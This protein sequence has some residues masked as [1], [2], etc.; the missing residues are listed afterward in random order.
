MR[1]L[2]VSCVLCVARDLSAFY[3]VHLVCLVSSA[4]Y[5]M[6]YQYERVVCVSTTSST[7]CLLACSTVILIYCRLACSTRSLK[8]ADQVEDNRERT[9]TWMRVRALLG[10]CPRLLLRCGV[11]ATSQHATHACIYKR[12]TC[13]RTMQVR[14]DKTVMWWWWRRRR[15]C[16]YWCW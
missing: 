11:K 12:N 10:L 8:H 2:Y 16:C 5:D 4:S 15:C 3:L 13:G 1:V 6:C 7:V 14:H 9:R